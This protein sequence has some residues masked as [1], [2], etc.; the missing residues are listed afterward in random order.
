MNIFVICGYGIPADIW[1]DQNYLTYLHVVFNKMFELSAGEEAVIIP[2][3]GPT[4]CIPP[5]KG[6]EAE[7]ISSYLNEFLQRP[8]L[9]T[10]TSAWKVIP[11]KRSLSTI[12]N[13]LFAREILDKGKLEGAI[14]IFAEKTREER[15]KI[16]AEEIFGASAMVHAIDFDTS[17]NRYI[18]PAIIQKKEADALNEGLWTLKEPERIEM[19]HT[20]F[21]KKFAF[22]RKRESE[23][24]SHIDA[25]AE[26]FEC[27]EELTRELMPDHPLLKKEGL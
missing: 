10:R 12:E 1:K 24:L 26:W 2:S 9:K 8:E 27:Q 19:H 20:L 18:N 16:F 11:E 5:Y 14:T 21:E 17:K 6:T 13:F 7:A 4:Q 25:V 22:L 3:G 15:L 23:G